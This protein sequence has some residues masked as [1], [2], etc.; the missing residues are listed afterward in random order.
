MYWYYYYYAS[1]NLWQ[2]TGCDRFSRVISLRTWVFTLVVWSGR[3]I[4]L[5]TLF[6]KT[7]TKFLNY[8][9][10]TKHNGWVIESKQKPEKNIARGIILPLQFNYTVLQPV[11]SSWWSCILLCCHYLQFTQADPPTNKSLANL[12]IQLLHFQEETFGKQNSNPALTKLPVSCHQRY[13]HFFLDLIALWLL[14]SIIT[15]A[16]LKFQAHCVTTTDWCT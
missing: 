1:A 6:V 13:H 11:T 4:Y 10:T 14:I 3:P 16:N 7:T 2:G 15:T 5:I 9:L 8:T 12:T